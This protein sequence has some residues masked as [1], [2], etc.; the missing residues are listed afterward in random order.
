[1]G[2]FSESTPFS[3]SKLDLYKKCYK[4]FKELDNQN[5]IIKQSW[6]D[7]AL[8]I[9]NFFGELC[10]AIWPLIILRLSRILKYVSPTISLATISKIVHTWRIVNDPRVISLFESE[11]LVSNAWVVECFRSRE[12][13]L[14]LHVL[15]F[16]QQ[17]C[18]IHRLSLSGRCYSTLPLTH[19]AL[20]CYRK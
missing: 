13:P 11:D 15:T 19:I 4:Y 10:K 18:S 16:L 7:M 6:Q 3:T 2:I 8:G 1:M 20:I 9:A 5:A 14:F 17:I 12:W